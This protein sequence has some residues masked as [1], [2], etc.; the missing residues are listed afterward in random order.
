MTFK[1]IRTNSLTDQFVSQMENKIFSGEL[2]PGYRMP[3][4]RD[5]V[6]ELGVSQTV[7]N[8]G[9]SILAGRGLLKI[10]P[11]KGTFV[12]DYKNEG[13]LETLS[14]LI[15]Y[16]GKH[17]PDR[18]TK[19]MY[20][21]RLICEREYMSLA[22]ARMTHK[23]TEELA[24]LVGIIRANAD[25]RERFAEAFY[26]VIRYLA[27]KSG[28]TVFLMICNGFCSM[29]L[30]VFGKLHEIGEPQIY[31]DSIESICRKIAAGDIEGLKEKILTFQQYEL[32]NLE[33]HGFF[34][35]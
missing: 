17:L 28:S 1:P 8:N 15:D 9:F 3:P 6:K 20:R 4:E 35:S 33:N 2:P 7:I 27:D 25:D 10:V 14:A 19:D 5:L 13:G 16:A 12:A 29:Y 26:Q 24:R 23:E 11:R 21:F 32:E 34:E 18:I 31:L 30:S 22:A